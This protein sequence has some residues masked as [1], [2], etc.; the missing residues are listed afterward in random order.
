MAAPLC[1]PPASFLQVDKSVYL[2]TARHAIKGVTTGLMARGRSRLFDVVGQ[3]GMA[4]ASRAKS[5]TLRCSRS[6]RHLKTSMPFT[7]S[8]P[9]C[10]Q[11]LSRSIIRT[12]GPSAASRCPKNDPAVALDRKTKMVTSRCYP[13]F[14]T[15]DF[16]G[17]YRAFGKSPDIHIGLN[18][19]PGTDN[20]G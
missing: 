11:A 15:V 18:Y 4:Q 1:L 2:V 5:S 20:G 3:G 14:G 12:R 8:R 6:I 17:D 7:P 13:Y 10:S 9:P 16:D 19:E